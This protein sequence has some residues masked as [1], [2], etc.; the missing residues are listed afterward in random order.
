VRCLARSAALVVVIAGIAPSSFAQESPLVFTV[1]VPDRARSSPTLQLSA[2]V[3]ERGL[4]LWSGAASDF[5]VGV[6][7]STSRWTVRSVGSMTVLPVD[8]HARPTF[9]QFEVIRPVFSAGSTSIAGGGG[10]RQE[11]DGTSVIVGRLLAASD[12]GEGRLQG[13]LVVERAISSPIRRDAADFI[14]TLGWSRPVGHRLSVG[15]EAIGQDLEGF[16]NPAEAEGG[17][18]VLVGPTVHAQ[19]TS[20]SWAASLTAGSVL[21]TLS[22][23][24]SW[25]PPV[26]AGRHFGFFASASWVPTLGHSTASAT[27]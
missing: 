4:A 2:V 18:K 7:L 11:W 24:T 14:T 5:G 16:W 23:V 21:Q 15:V 12:V 19:S 26:S 8:G 6:T 9:Q 1:A 10:V 25:S 22:T 27:H 17:A 13:S 20:G 3:E